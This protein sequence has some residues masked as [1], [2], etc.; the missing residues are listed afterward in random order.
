MKNR[1]TPCPILHNITTGDIFV[2]GTFKRDI[3][4]YIYKIHL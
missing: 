1:R 3:K 4:R 2:R